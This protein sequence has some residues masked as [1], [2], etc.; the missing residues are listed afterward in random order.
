MKKLIKLGL[1]I[2]ILGLFLAPLPGDFAYAAEASLFL[3]PGS[4]EYNMGDSFNVDV[5][6]N[7]GGENGINAS[8]AL[9][10]FDTSYLL[11]KNVSKSNSIFNLWTSEPTF[12][13]NGG[14]VNY[15]GGSP[16]AYK[17]GAGVVMTIT[18]MSLKVGE[19]SVSFSQASTL[20]ADGKGTNILAG[21]EGA[22]FTFKEK[23]EKPKE[24]PKE[25]PKE[26]P[27]EKPKKEPMGVFPPPPKVKSSTHPEEDLWYPNNNPEFEWKLLIDVSGVSFK[28]NTS[29][30][31]DPGVIS[32]GIIESKKFEDIVDGENYFHIKFKNKYGWGPITHRK[33][34]IDSTPPLDFEII[35]DNEDDPTDPRPNI[36]FEVIDETSGVEKYIINLDGKP[37]EIAENDLKKNP[38]EFSILK[39]G[40]HNIEISAT[41]YAG[42]RASSSKTFLVD[43]LKAP[44]ITE[45]STILLKGEELVV[46]GTSFYPNAT[47][48]IYILKDGDENPKEVEVKTDEDGNWTYFQKNDLGKGVYR[49][50]AK[51]IDYRGAESYESLKKTLIVKSPSIICAYGFW[52][53]LF[54]LLVIIGLIMV[55][56]YLQRT[57]ERQKVRAMRESGEL[58]KRLA[59]IFTA[60]KEE[61][62]E[63]IEF[64]DKKKGVSES[65]LRAKEKIHEA[66]DISQEFIGK[67][68]KDVKK[69]IDWKK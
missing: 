43:A 67:E 61:V 13:N 29:S 59:E 21:T 35:I 48:K 19:T 3:R 34:L 10:K 38:Y 23:E 6:V 53:I 69:E 31:T 56:I 15:S 32:T 42:N 11:V 66:L 55:I 37:F 24:E 50:W 44:V 52:I 22:K 18:F 65:E 51:V 30:T 2:L 36:N 26:K 14:T 25:E 45:M 12:S 7:S 60:L 33:V 49:V 17:G 20:A 46:Q 47:I 40:Q 63:L 28:L 57:H 1:F 27:K 9:I 16:T 41:D 62:S 4:G 68:I 54:L 8:D 64:A 58:E 39:P 5:I